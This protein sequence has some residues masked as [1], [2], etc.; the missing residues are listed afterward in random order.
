MLNLC[1]PV[2]SKWTSIHHTELETKHQNHFISSKRKKKR[3]EKVAPAAM[4]HAHNH[5]AGKMLACNKYWA[6][7]AKSRSSA[8][9]FNE[10]S[11]TAN[12]SNNDN[13][14]KEWQ[15]GIATSVMAENRSN[16]NSSVDAFPLR[17]FSFALFIDMGRSSASL[18]V[19][20]IG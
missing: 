6:N 14:C 7:Y 11:K 20:T 10:R 12:S 19:R 1:I 9:E 4:A 18:P 8:I 16:T 3:K 15:C 17:Q 13:E 2:L 5:T